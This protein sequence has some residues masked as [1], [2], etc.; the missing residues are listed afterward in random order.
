MI[1]AWVLM[2]AGLLLSAQDV[3]EARRVATAFDGLSYLLLVQ[4]G[5]RVIQ[6]GALD[7]EEALAPCSTYKLPH[8]LIGLDRG[9]I[10]PG[11]DV[12]TCDPDRCHDA[13]GRLGMA[14]AIRVSC[15]SYFRQVARELGSEREAAGLKALGYPV[16][17]NLQPLED[18]WLRGTGLRLT[19]RQQLT[20][21]RRFY[22]ED[23]PV[24]KVHLEAVRAASRRTGT[25][26]WTLWGKPGSSDPEA[27]AVHGW[28]I[29]KVQ[30]KEGHTSYVVVLV[31][32]KG[33]GLG[34]MGLRAQERLERLLRK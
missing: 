29:G 18:F 25:A 34:L 19:A 26:D 14:E 2:F 8:A 9:V 27:P 16:T 21:I 1:R 17:G 24:A 3:W 7:P 23:L 33:K 28:F 10:V 5:D 20:W 31:K 13:H 4:E 22:S 32:G 6:R 15:L 11:G 12:R 30:W